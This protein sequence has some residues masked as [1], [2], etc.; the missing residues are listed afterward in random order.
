VNGSGYRQTKT[1]PKEK[2]KL[3]FLKSFWEAWRL[4][5]ELEGTGMFLDPKITEFFYLF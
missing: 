1:V 4:L 3:L 2:E 5:L